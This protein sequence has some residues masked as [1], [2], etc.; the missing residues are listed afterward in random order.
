M[1]LEELE[2][3]HPHPLNATSVY[4]AV[5][6][7]FFIILLKV[8]IFLSLAFWQKIVRVNPGDKISFPL[9]E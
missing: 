2:E 6:G 5:Y 1:G 4:S 9:N 7:L 3:I 8:R